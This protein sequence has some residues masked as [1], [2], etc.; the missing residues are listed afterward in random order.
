MRGA[1]AG[2]VLAAMLLAGCT[3]TYTSIDIF[4]DQAGYF[5]QVEAAWAAG[6]LN[7]TRTNASWNHA[8][9]TGM[10]HLD[11]GPTPVDAGNQSL[12]VI[13][14]VSGTFRADGK[15]REELLAFIVDDSKIKGEVK[16]SLSDA[17]AAKPLRTFLRASVTMGQAQ[18][19]A[20][21]E[22]YL[23]SRF[24]W[25]P[26]PGVSFLGTQLDR[27]IEAEHL[28]ANIGNLEAKA[29]TCCLEDSV[30]TWPE[31]SSDD[32][33]WRLRF[34]VASLHLEPG[35]YHERLVVTKADRVYVGNFVHEVGMSKADA[36]QQARL[37]VERAGW[38]SI[39]FSEAEVHLLEGSS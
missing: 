27:Q 2:A 38:P 35:G 29:W 23:T 33:S 36:I 26:D 3:T 13:E 17:Q 25:E 37:L 32:G 11:H 28:Q 21:V 5:A 15:T 10:F 30:I 18:E 16:A 19:D 22:S 14:Y 1:V 6:M 34:T 24:R 8:S 7:A 4:V 9:V 31:Y 20:T 39:D 12:E